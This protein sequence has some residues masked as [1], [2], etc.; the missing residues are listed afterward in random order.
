[1]N[2]NDLIIKE[3]KQLYSETM[4]DYN[5]EA[6]RIVIENRD[7]FLSDPVNATEIEGLVWDSALDNVLKKLG[8]G[9]LMAQNV[10]AVSNY[11]IILKDKT[12][13]K[14]YEC[15]SYMV[16][17]KNLYTQKLIQIIDFQSCREAR[18]KA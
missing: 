17:S 7:S 2:K 4:D 6:I 11:N 9:T 15:I 3:A 8:Y 5:V 1:M 13:G 12:N 14:M 16:P 18:S 10:D